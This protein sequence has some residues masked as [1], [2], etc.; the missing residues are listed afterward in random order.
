MR[1][2]CSFDFC[3]QGTNVNLCNRSITPENLGIFP[4][5]W[6]RYFISSRPSADQSLPCFAEQRTSIHIAHTHTH[7]HTRIFD[8]VVR[9]SKSPRNLLFDYSSS[10]QKRF[11]RFLSWFSPRIINIHLR[12]TFIIRVS[13]TC[14]LCITC[15][16]Y[17]S[18]PGYKPLT[19]LHPCFWATCPWIVNF[20]HYCFADN[21]V[22]YHSI[23]LTFVL[24]L[25][26]D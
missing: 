21:H 13:P 3:A 9:F 5:R 26:F 2:W 15:I 22:T 10:N 16:I 25:K 8:S 23:Q 12:V 6:D 7:I 11:V 19:P 18:R 14:L 1:V 20:I 4:Y 24:Y 17:T